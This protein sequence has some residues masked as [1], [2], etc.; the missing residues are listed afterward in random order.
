MTPLRYG[1]FERLA[2][3]WHGWRDGRAGIPRPA[4]GPLSTPH[5][6]VLVTRAREAFEREWIERE[7][8]WAGDQQRLAASVTE[9]AQAER[10]LARAEAELAELPPRPTGEE[11]TRRRLG[12][13]QRPE[14]IVRLRRFREHAGRR[15][16][17]KREV[18]A[19]RARVDEVEQEVAAI[20]DLLERHALVALARVRRLHEY[21]HLRL[22]SYRRRLVRGHRY[23]PLV[24]QAMDMLDPRFPEWARETGDEAGPVP[25]SETAQPLPEPPGETYPISDRLV[26]GADEGKADVVI[27][28]YDVGAEHA[29]VERKGG[30]LLLRDLGHGSGTFQG[31][32]PVSHTHLVPGDVF[33]I[34]DYRF[35]V[36]AD[37]LTL[38][39]TR[40]GTCD[41]VVC[42]LS[43]SARIKDQ[44]VPRL[45]RMSFTQRAGTVLAIVGPSGGGK[46]SLFS[47]LL[48]ELPSSGDM[49]FRGLNVHTHLDQ[50]RPRLG[51]VPQQDSLLPSLTVRQTLTYADRL[52]APSDVPPDPPAAE[53]PHVVDV[54]RRLD[55]ERCLDKTLDELSGGQRK[56]VSIAVE[57]LAQP[58][59]LMLDEPTSG[60]DAGMDRDVMRI[61]RRIAAE[62]CT[63]IVVT[64][65]TE[66][67]FLAD[68]VVVLGSQGRVVFSGRPARLPEDLGRHDYAELM[69]VLAASPEALA[70]KY[71]TSPEAEEARRAAKVAKEASG[72]RTPERA[73]G[74]FTVFRHQ[75]PVLLSR[76]VALALPVAAALRAKTEN[77]R[78]KAAATALMPF[79]V[80]G[81]SAFL[82]ALV[83]SAPGLGQGS[84]DAPVVLSVLTTLSVLT[85]Q[86]LTYSNLVEEGEVIRRECRT[87]M[88]PWAVVAAKWLVFA[89]VAL[90]QSAVVTTVFVLARPGPAHS[91]TGLS[92]PVELFTDL[93]MTSVAALSLGLLISACC[94]E[95]KQAVTAASLTVIAQVVLNGVTSTLSDR[96][97]WNL[98]AMLLPAR[99]GLAA[100]AS[101]IDLPAIAPLTPA[102]ALWRHTLGQWLTDLGA[103][104]C[105]T[106]LFVA[107]ATA[108][109][110]RRLAPPRR[111]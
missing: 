50:I 70:E 93:A 37:G 10:E 62:D 44:V 100:S 53:P 87:G 45:T 103:L 107:G 20:R 59:L 43:A 94:R 109:L 90:G 85:G 72:T 19:A 78:R 95:L 29:V 76:Q 55:I 38:V 97:W 82:A 4:R 63:V 28:G 92:P 13:A 68:Q 39:K 41:L 91:V 98:P 66:H 83:A 17:L 6:D 57:I 42:D 31:G 54:C 106:A 40:L 56:R 81:L 101:S 11:L 105:L 1:P 104:G 36:G 84:P 74:S 9:L 89:L 88:L 46:S 51:F 48:K 30:R 32:V 79:A 71:L 8:G 52:R 73:R 96:P 111:R 27:E 108:V 49:Y 102:D 7:A 14:R 67:L 23:G 2:D 69:K 35:Q 16:Q 86:A 75:V 5:R 24:N 15:A 18:R 22:A 80:A 60:L 33:D 65:S 110:R 3:W 26:I 58:H 21:T 61:L 34:S 99:W 64:H 77:Q 47:A 25:D 12:E